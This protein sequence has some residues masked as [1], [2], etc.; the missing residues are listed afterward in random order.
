MH[1]EGKSLIPK[2]FIKKI[3]NSFKNI[4]NYGEQLDINELWIYLSD[5]I[6][7]E[8]NTKSNYY[9]LISKNT[10]DDKIK[11]GIIVESDN[12][13]NRMLLCSK[14]LK[15]KFTYYN[16]KLNENKTSE[17]LNS[18]QGF[19]L[20]ITSCMECNNRLYNF[21]SFTTLNLNLTDENVSIVDMIKQI[22][23]IEYD[24]Q[25]WEC[26]HCKKKTKNKKQMKLWNLPD[27]LF[28]TINRFTD[29][30]RKNNNPVNINENLN[31]NKGSILSNTDIEKKYKLS[32]IGL[33]IGSL[34]GGHY[35]AICNFDDNYYLYN[36]LSVK[37]IEDNNFLKNNSAAYMLVYNKL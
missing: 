4:F 9:K 1:E 32:S 8:L 27:V 16:I 23:K 5:Y 21:E 2:K 28:I 24:C 12:E 33:H 25:D 13:F 19:Y 10:I 31:F 30:M 37:K 11:D 14:N 3:F 6:V 36:D 26:E 15:D 17:W 22:Y 18:I 7:N 20:N 35:M 34:N 29:I